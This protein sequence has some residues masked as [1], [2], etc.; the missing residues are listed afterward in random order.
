MSNFTE[1][2]KT[3]L[4]CNTLANI[5]EHSQAQK[6]VLGQTLEFES[7]V[8]GSNDAENEFTFDESP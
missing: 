5:C 3:L 1:L 2:L 7:F 6:H 4:G 8:L